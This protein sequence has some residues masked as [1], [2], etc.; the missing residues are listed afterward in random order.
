VAAVTA[1]AVKRLQA[2]LYAADSFTGFEEDFEG[3]VRLETTSTTLV[4]SVSADSN[5]TDLDGRPGLQGAAPFYV[6][7]VRWGGTQSRAVEF[8]N[9]QAQ[10]H[11][12]PN[13]T[14]VEVVYWLVQPYAVYEVGPDATWLELVPL[15]S[16]VAVEEV[17]TVEHA[18]TFTF[19]TAVQP[20]QYGI[21]ING[22]PTG[23]TE[24]T[25]YVFLWAIDADGASVGNVAWRKDSTTA[26]QTSSGNILSGI[27]LEMNPDGTFVEGASFGGCPRCRIQNGG[28]TTAT[29]TFTTNPADLGAAPSGT[30]RFVGRSRIPYGCS[31]TWAADDGV[32]GWTTLV[33]GQDVTEVGLAAQQSYDVRVTLTTN[34]NLDATPTVTAIGVEEVALTRLDPMANTTG[35]PT[36]GIDPW[37]LKGEITSATLQVLH[38]GIKDYR[39]A[40]TTLLSENDTGDMDVRIWLG[41]DT[42]DR[43]D[44]FLV[45]QF[46]VDDTQGL[47]AAGQVELLSP[48]QLLRNVLPVYSIAQASRVPYEIAA[49]TITAAYA[50]IVD[51]QVALPDRYRGDGPVDTEQVTKTVVDSDAKDEL[52]ALAFLAGG[53]LTSSQGTVKYVDFMG[54]K[55]VRA[56]FPMA[57][58]RQIAVSPG[59]GKRTPEYFIPYAWDQDEE[60]YLS[61]Q[62]YINQTAFDA[63]GLGRIWGVQTLDDTVAQYIPS[64]TLADRIGA[65]AIEFFSTGQITIEFESVYA[66]PELEPGDAVAVQTDRLIVKVPGSGQAIKGRVWALGIV[67]AVRGW[68]GRHFTVWVRSFADILATGTAVDVT[69]FLARYRC[70]VYDSGASQSVNQASSPVNMTWNSEEYDPGSMHDTGTNP[71]RITIAATGTYLLQFKASAYTSNGGLEGVYFRKNNSSTLAFIYGNTGTTG[72]FSLDTTVELD[73]GD[74]VEVQLQS[75]SGLGGTLTITTGSAA[76]CSFAVTRLR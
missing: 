16:P 17:G 31:V 27:Q 30:V 10:L 76:A 56:V 70:K 5:V 43:G 29:L 15:A 66:Y 59:F 21:P 20:K 53:G 9:F 75:Y 73:A 26:S 36:W 22:I 25:T 37:T 74:Y 35:V 55:P 60:R 24:P 45:D 65:R 38:D 52:D 44:W 6:A 64:S 11:P 19:P 71:S 1:S 68:W 12:N 67:A 41:S 13:G 57:E 63:L 34:T 39:D 40:I 18:V 61:E 3:G 33:D 32:A 51:N 14:G 28:Y 42:I 7:K 49:A 58:T 2:D 54:D 62:R 8:T 48:L 47:G 23:F 46:L 4:Q 72:D 69:G 50:D